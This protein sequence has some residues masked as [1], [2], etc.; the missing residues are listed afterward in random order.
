MYK[1]D[2]LLSSFTYTTTWMHPCRVIS[3]VAFFLGLGINIIVFVSIPF[4]TDLNIF[5][6][7][8]D[9]AAPFNGTLN[10]A[11]AFQNLTSLRVSFAAFFLLKLLCPTW[12]I[13]P[14]SWVTGK[15]A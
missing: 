7:E 15:D 13:F 5:I 9:F 11:L 8:I 2:A 6:A 14:S 3:L 12:F 4:L 1:I 10:N